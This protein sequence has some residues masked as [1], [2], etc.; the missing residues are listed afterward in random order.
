M[1]ILNGNAGALSNWEVLELLKEVKHG[2]RRN[3]QSDLGMVTY[4]CMKFLENTPCKDQD[5]NVIQNYL[6][7]LMPFQLTKSEKLMLINN[8]PRTELEIQLIVEDSEDRLTE[9]QVQEMLKIFEMP[10]EIQ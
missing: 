5:A 9:S 8:P 2:L 7:A 1:E 4:E 6:R 3:T 10:S